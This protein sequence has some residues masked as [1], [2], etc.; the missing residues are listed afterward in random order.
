MES[1]SIFDENVDIYEEWF[2]KNNFILE[3]EVNAIRQLLPNFNYGI[4][5]G[6]GTGIFASELGIKD[7][8]E[9]SLEMGK[10]ATKKG[11]HVINA[12]AE[13][14]P[15]ADCTY[16]IALMVTV[17][18]F[19]TDVL[20]AFKE[21]HRI[22]KEDGY[23][24]IA[25]IDRETLLGQMYDQRK[26]SDQ[27]Y[28]NANFRSAAEM[29]SLLRDAGFEITDR[30]QTIFSFDNTLQEIKAGNGEGVFAVIKVKKCESV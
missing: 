8:I 21:V 15:I 26:N 17:D 13:L 5:I 1:I 9:P 25:F 11:I 16:Q 3:T 18:C 24:I 20:Q 23:F 29:T 28:K 7:G 6:T 27:F 19:L 30:R 22:L 14:L 2:H 12:N 4:E 10:R